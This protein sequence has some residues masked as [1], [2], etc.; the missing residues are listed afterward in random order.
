MTFGY[1]R[2]LQESLGLQDFF[3]GV[4]DFV[5]RPVASAYLLHLVHCGLAMAAGRPCTSRLGRESGDGYGRTC[6]LYIPVLNF[7]YMNVFNSLYCYF[8]LIPFYIFSLVEKT[9]LVERFLCRSTGHGKDTSCCTNAF[10]LVVPL[11]LSE[12]FPAVRA[13]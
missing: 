5:P 3:Q 13:A 4:T 1:F 6:T 7:V 8:M 10:R 9:D 12:H 11:P 2:N